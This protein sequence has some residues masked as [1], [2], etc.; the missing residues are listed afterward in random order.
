VHDIDFSV[1]SLDPALRAAIA[2]LPG[3]RIIH[4]NGTADYAVR[5]LSARGLDGLWD[6]IHGIE[7]SERHIPKPHLLNYAAIHARDGLDPARAAMF[8]DSARNLLVPHRLGMMTVHVSSL[9]EPAPHL[10]HHTN[11]LTAFLRDISAGG[12]AAP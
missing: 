1:L 6:A 12:P 9:H 3:R 4:T 10:H 11:D 2:S 8:E 5:V 7:H